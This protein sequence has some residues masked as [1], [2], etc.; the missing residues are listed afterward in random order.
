MNSLRKFLKDARSSAVN[1]PKPIRIVLGNVSCDMDSTVGC[2]GL[3]YFYTLK[4]SEDWTPVINCNRDDFKLKN[5]I[6][7]H[8]V[9]DCGIKTEELLFWDEFIVLKREIIEVA[10]ID[11][12]IL[13]P[14]QAVALQADSKITRVID[15]HFDNKHYPKEQLIEY[16]VKFIGSACS[17]L[18]Q[19]IQNDFKLFSASHWE[20]TQPNFAYF[21]GA[22]IILDTGNEN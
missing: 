14:E 1:T 5:D 11:H 7:G 18:V 19:M 10:L 6:I 15:H 17:I 16:V 4:S 8:V 12:N 9:K 21:L 2:I 3:S 13:D 20:E 22:P